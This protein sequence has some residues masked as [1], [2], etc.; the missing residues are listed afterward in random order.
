MTIDYATTPGAALDG[1]DYQSATGTLQFAAGETLKT[2]P[3]AITSSLL[4]EGI[5]SF[6][7]TFSHAADGQSARDTAKVSRV[8]NDAA[9][10]MSVSDEGIDVVNTG[11]QGLVLTFRLSDPSA[12]IVRLAYTTIDVTPRTTA[13]MRPGEF[14]RSR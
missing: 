13:R 6:S 4:I 8:D 10:V 12:Q 11:P 2:I 9:P 14:R 5:E 1:F 7:V 3:L